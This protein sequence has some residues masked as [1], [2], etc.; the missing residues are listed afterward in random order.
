MVRKKIGVKK[1][2]MVSVKCAS[3][4]IE[5]FDGR[6]DFTSW[7]QRV[8]SLLTREGTSKALKVKSHRIAKM[9]DNEWVGLRKKDKP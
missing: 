8:K 1:H 3:I 6:G 7:Q 9:T 2:G 4:S 5:P